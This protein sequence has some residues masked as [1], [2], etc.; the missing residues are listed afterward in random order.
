MLRGC[1]AAAPQDGGTCF[2]A[3]HK[4]VGK[5]LRAHGIMGKAVFS[6]HRITGVGL[7]DQRTFHESSQTAHKTGSHTVCRHT[8]KAHGSG[9]GLLQ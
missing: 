2:Y 4:G 1:T 7:A 9:T 5:F 6:Y 8:V 3:A